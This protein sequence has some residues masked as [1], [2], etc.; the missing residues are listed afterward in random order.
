MSIMVAVI[1]LE[2]VGIFYFAEKKGFLGGRTIVPVNVRLVSESQ[3]VD[4]L[5][6]N[7][8][9]TSSGGQIFCTYRTLGESE[10]TAQPFHA[11][12]WALCGEFSF[13]EGKITKGKT[14]SSPVDLVARTRNGG[15]EIASHKM[16]GAASYREDIKGIFP[17]KIQNLIFRYT[18]SGKV[19][20]MESELSSM[21]K[22]SLQ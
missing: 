18:T 1:M 16:P 6:G 17:S 7:L 8:L 13:K 3:I 9:T 12:V 10:L 15:I 14:V 20:E 11:Y 19:S 2:L 22:S 5:K 4:Y 21:A